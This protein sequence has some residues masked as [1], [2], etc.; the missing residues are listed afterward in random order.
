MN[1]DEKVLNLDMN[2]MSSITWN[3]YNNSLEN[4]LIL[5]DY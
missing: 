3:I 5:L 2:L 1:Q 4:A